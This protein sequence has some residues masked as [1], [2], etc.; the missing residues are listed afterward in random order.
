LKVLAFGG[1]P[2]TAAAGR[3]KLTP[4]RLSP[5]ASVV[6]IATLRCL[7]LVTVAAAISNLRVR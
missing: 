5:N 3:V 2:M 6:R 4:R 7:V 1:A